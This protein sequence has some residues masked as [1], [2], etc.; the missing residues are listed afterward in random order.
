MTHEALIAAIQAGDTPQAVELL[1]ATPSLAEARAESGVS[2]LLMAIYYGQPEIA[3]EIA[4]RRVQIDVFEAAALGDDVRVRDL[5]ADQPEQLDAASDDGF[6]PLGLA[7][8]FGHEDVADL[9]LGL[10]ASPDIASRNE[11]RVA[12]LHS[13]AAGQHLAIAQLLIDRGADVNV[14]QQGGFTPLHAAAQNGQVALIELL[15]DH[16]AD[17]HATTDAGK[18]PLDLASE[19]GA[20]AAEQRLS[21]TQ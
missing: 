19:S 17:P 4:A 16:G 9:L 7:A 12:P 1:D 15:L 14:R 21:S 11:Q 6:T 13:A 3:Q 5:L 2:L 10:G 18:T 8:F 20:T